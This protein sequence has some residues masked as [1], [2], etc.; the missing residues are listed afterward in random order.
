MTIRLIVAL[1]GVGSSSA[2][3]TS[4]ASVMRKTTG[5][6]LVAPE[7]TDPFDMG[8][9]GRQ[10][11]SL[12]GI[13]DANRASRISEALPAML[14]KVDALRRERGLERGAVAL[15]GFSQGAI[16][17]LGAVA[18][19]EAFGAS[20]AIAGRLA[21]VL[22][23]PPVVPRPILLVHD[24]SDQIM[25]LD[26][27]ESAA[28]RLRSAGYRPEMAITQGYGHSIGPDTIGAM[29]AFIERI[30]RRADVE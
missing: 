2:S 17:T 16:M 13:T 14:D 19:G 24:R 6:E 3:F 27:A 11:F 8:A 15:A 12:R 21:S 29:V 20:I 23:P 7:G 4:I 26:H 25:P 30:R 1:H 18:S 10:W 22:D 28:A 9:P 5:V